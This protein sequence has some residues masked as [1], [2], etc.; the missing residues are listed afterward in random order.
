MLKHLQQITNKH[1]DIP[2]S[3]NSL[4]VGLKLKNRRGQTNSKPMNI[5]LYRPI[6]KCLTSIKMQG[7]RTAVGGKQSNK[8][9]YFSERRRQARKSELHCYVNSFPFIRMLF[10][11]PRRNILIF[12]PIFGRKS[13]CIFLRL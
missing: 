5:R 12:L 11:R 10:F 13:S 7:K 9:N 8:L 1:Y 3:Q 6:S 2:V 4:S